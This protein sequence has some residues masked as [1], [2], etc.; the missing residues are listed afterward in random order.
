[1]RHIVQ[2]MA[3]LIDDLALSNDE[4]AFLMDQLRRPLD[5]DSL[6]NLAQDKEQAVEALCCVTD[7]Y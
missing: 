2:A 5:I 4:K 1:M 3:I 7:G 6:V